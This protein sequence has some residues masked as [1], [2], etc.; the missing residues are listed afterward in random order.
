MTSLA[1]CGGYIDE[2]SPKGSIIQLENIPCYISQKE[3]IEKKDIA[4]ILATDIFGFTLPNIRLIADAYNEEGKVLTIIP[5][6]FEGKEPPADLLPQINSM[7][8]GN[9]SIFKRI[10]YFCRLCWYF[11]PFLIRVSWQ[12]G[13]RRV[14]KISNILK[15]DFGIKKVAVQ[16]YCWG[17]KIAI[18]L[19]HEENVIDCFS[20][21][22]PGGLSLPLDIERI[23]KPAC[24]I[25]PEKDFELQSRQIQLIKE[26]LQ[27][28]SE[29]NFSFPYTVRYYP[30][31]VHG[32]AVRGDEN[33]LE[34][35]NARKDA[36]D[37]SLHFFKKILQF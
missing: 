37:V 16:G 36:F 21:A 1:C 33:D 17:G 34:V 2:G 24:F 8:Y 7:M 19:A 26:V 9:I 20:S 28:K 13:V 30:G 11:I 22:H 4:I 31:M 10:Y 18:K 32:F 15:R 27:M 3:N 5:D 23:Q 25:L 35:R 12:D 14:E 6:L 29:S